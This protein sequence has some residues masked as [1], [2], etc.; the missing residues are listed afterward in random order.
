MPGFNESRHFHKQLR[1]QGELKT[2]MGGS[3]TPVSAEQSV[4]GQQ[5]LFDHLTLTDRP[6]KGRMTRPFVLL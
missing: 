1:Q 6:K 2:R 5:W 4:A 3:S